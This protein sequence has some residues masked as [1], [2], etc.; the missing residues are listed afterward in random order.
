MDSKMG[1]IAEIFDVKLGENFY[2]DFGQVED[3][4]AIKGS[5]F[6]FDEVGLFNSSQEEYDNQT[7][8]ELLA[9]YFEIIKIPY[10]PNFLETFYTY[11]LKGDKIILKE[12][13]WT[14]SFE[15]LLYF[16]LGLVYK[17]EEDAEKDLLKAIEFFN[18]N[19]FFDW[20]KLYDNKT[21]PINC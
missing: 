7:L 14:D 16:H 15:N 3:K 4:N 2:I 10:K 8:I 18:S 1:K 12:C 5:I 21:T 20:K 9:G 11:C 13:Q 6:F 19:K 17:T